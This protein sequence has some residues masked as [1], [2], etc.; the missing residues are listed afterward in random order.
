MSCIYSIVQKP[1]FHTFKTPPGC[2]LMVDLR[3]RAFLQPVCPL[4]EFM[5]SQRRDSA[6]HAGAEVFDSCHSGATGGCGSWDGL[7]KC[8]EN[9]CRSTSECRTFGRENKN[10]NL[11]IS[12]ISV[13]LVMYLENVLTPTELLVCALSRFF[14]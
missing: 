3:Q 9:A 10:K 14:F 13:Y 7:V 2:W 6:V 11:L 8:C 1:I 4:T 12:E 5:N